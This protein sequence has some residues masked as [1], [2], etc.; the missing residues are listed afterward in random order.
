MDSIISP[1]KD[2]DDVE[3]YNPA[4]EIYIGLWTLLVS[5]TVFLASRLWVKLRRHGL[6][7]DDHIL[8]FAYVSVHFSTSGY[9]RTNLL[10]SIQTTLLITDI[11]ITVEYATGYSKGHWDDRM[12]MLINTSSIGTVIGQ[13]VSKTAFAVT[14]LRMVDSR[15]QSTFLWFCVVTMDGIAFSKCFLQW[16][17][18][19]GRDDYQQWYRLQTPCV[20]YTFVQDWKEIGN[21]K[22]S[23][24]AQRMRLTSTG[25]R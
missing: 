4:A 19:C 7:Y 18:L 12:H 9:C 1:R 3:Y 8:I 10:I 21:S 13:A 2:D 22:W 14:L 6:W 24:L 25:R 20:N 16:S 17:K 11:L 15:W 23:C 5:A